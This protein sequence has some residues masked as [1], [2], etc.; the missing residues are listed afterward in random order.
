[1]PHEKSAPATAQPR[2]PAARMSP[3]RRRNRQ[4]LLDAAAA[5]LDENVLPTVAEA[6]DRAEISRATAYRYF[7]SP[8]QLQN[9]AA[10]DV[11]AKSIDRL[12]IA[13]GE[14]VP[15]EEAVARLVREVH[16]MSLRHELAFRTMLRL[17]LDPT[18]GGRGGRRIGW[19]TRLLEQTSLREDVRKRAV[20]A[21]SILCGIE[22]H[23]VLNDVC[24]LS[25]EDA[26]DTLDWA[27]RALVR[28][29]AMDSSRGTD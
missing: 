5:Y 21:L 17:S 6:A 18:G 3:L 29:A 2:S 23:I 12:A 9:E 7:S 28:A 1:M 27:A 10:L 25:P 20:P 4:A 13:G 15:P 26:A 16:A 22:A 8:E 19:I 14:N 11:I 24:G